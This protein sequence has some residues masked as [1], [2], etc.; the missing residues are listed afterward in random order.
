MPQISSKSKYI[1]IFALG[2]M[3]FCFIESTEY[4]DRCWIILSWRMMTYTQNNGYELWSSL[5]PNLVFTF[6][7]IKSDKDNLIWLTTNRMCFRLLLLERD[8]IS[9]VMCS[10]KGQEFND[11]ILSNRYFPLGLSFVFEPPTHNTENLV[12]HFKPINWFSFASFINIPHHHFWKLI[13]GYSKLLFS[14]S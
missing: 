6:T 10:V 1:W 11:E 4:F 3:L 8:V 9:L 12:L 13:Y 14:N 7:Q 5:L 2:N